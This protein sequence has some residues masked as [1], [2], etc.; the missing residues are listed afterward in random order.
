MLTTLFRLELKSTFRSPT[1]RQNLWM[2]ILIVFAILYFAVIFLSLGIGV[3]YIIE[4][5]ELG[6]FSSTSFTELPFTNK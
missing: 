5:L 1:W 3:Y 6:A 2:R 4:K